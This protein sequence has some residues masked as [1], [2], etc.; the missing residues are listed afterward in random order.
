MIAE[1]GF[2]CGEK[3]QN[4]T[5]SRS[6]TWKRWT[7]HL[8]NK[9][10]P[11]KS[12]TFPLIQNKDNTEKRIMTW[13]ASIIIFFFLPPR[14]SMSTFL[15]CSLTPIPTPKSVYFLLTQNSINHQYR[16]LCL[17]L[18]IF[19]YISHNDHEISLVRQVT[20]SHNFSDT[21]R[22]KHNMFHL[23]F[24]FFVLKHWPGL[25]P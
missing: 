7:L 22:N 2:F 10:V 14:Q 8:H 6:R 25:F 13:D 1:R 15:L 3:K 21:L 23:F 24:F 11:T 12:Y 16:R 4:K 17:T 18:F 19:V 9:E 20:V 5:R